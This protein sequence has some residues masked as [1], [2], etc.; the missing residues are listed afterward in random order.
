MPKKIEARNSL[1][2][3][4][5]DEMATQ[6][7]NIVEREEPG[8]K[9][10]YMLIGVDVTED[11]LPRTNIPSSNTALDININCNGI[12]LLIAQGLASFF[13]QPEHEL[14]IKGALKLVNGPISIQNIFEEIGKKGQTL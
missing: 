12:G 6:L 3:Y 9:R 13:K 8:R 10:A 11:T 4:T 1:F 2:Q 14:I 5:I 7:N